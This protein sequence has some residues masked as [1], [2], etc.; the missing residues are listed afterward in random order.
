MFSRLFEHGLQLLD[1]GTHI[2][3]LALL[4]VRLAC[5]QLVLKRSKLLVLLLRKRNVKL[6]GLDLRLTRRSFMKTIMAGQA[7]TRKLYGYYLE[8]SLKIAV[9]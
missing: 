9:R 1:L 3:R 7:R 2:L 8:T 6:Y 4:Q 5:L